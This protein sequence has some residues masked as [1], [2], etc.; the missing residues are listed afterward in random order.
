[1]VG[2]TEPRT[3]RSRQPPP[4]EPASLLRSMHVYLASCFS[5]LIRQLRSNTP[6]DARPSAHLSR[7]ARQQAC[8][9][10]AVSVCQLEGAGGGVIMNGEPL[11]A[12]CFLNALPNDLQ[13]PRRPTDT[14]SLLGRIFRCPG[15]NGGGRAPGGAHR[16]PG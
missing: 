5:H 12:H 13:V 16:L 1:M 2:E 3:S 10:S 7:S 9:S 15:K 4:A 6:A 14:G 11:R 8:G